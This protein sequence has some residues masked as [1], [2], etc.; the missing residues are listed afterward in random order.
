MLRSSGLSAWFTAPE[1]KRNCFN[2]INSCS[3][4]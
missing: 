2:L 3:Q 4:W 1:R